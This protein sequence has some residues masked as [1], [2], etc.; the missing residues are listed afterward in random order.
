MSYT[1]GRSKSLEDITLS[2]VLQYPI[3]EWALENETEQ[4]QD[5]TWQQ[6]VIDT[7]NVT[8]EIYCPIITLSI[9]GTNLF[10]SAEFDHDTQ[11]LSSISVWADSQWKILADI[12]I[13]TPIV[14][15]SI[16]KIEGVEK[17][18]FICKTLFA[19][20]AVKNKNR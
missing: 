4:M 18:E 7:D 9:K 19:D 20:R 13:Q 6:P 10:A 12:Q 8:D 5:E 15:V 17:T 11:S 16:P 1:T 14:F 2:D 3:W